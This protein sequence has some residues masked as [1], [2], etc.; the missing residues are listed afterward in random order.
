MF[1]GKSLVN[2]SKFRNNTFSMGKD[3]EIRSVHKILDECQTPWGNSKSAL[4]IY[5]YL[6]GWEAFYK[7]GDS[8]GY[9]RRAEMFQKFHTGEK[10]R[11]ASGLGDDARPWILGFVKF[12][13]DEISQMLLQD[14]GAPFNQSTAMCPNVSIPSDRRRR[15]VPQSS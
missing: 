2:L 12:F 3:N 9:E 1:I 11:L 7:P 4:A 15:R 5:H 13:G 10:V 8:R 14:A 6:G